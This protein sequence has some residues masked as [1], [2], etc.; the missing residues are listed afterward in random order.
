MRSWMVLLLLC[1]GPLGASAQSDNCATATL[2]TECTLTPSGNAGATTGSDD[3]F[4]P[5]QICAT[6]ADQTVW[7]SFTASQT[8]PYTLTVSNVACSGITQI[9]TGIFSGTCGAL[10]ALN[11]GQGSSGLVTSF[12]AV[13]GQTYFLVFDGAAASDCGFD[14]LVCAG[15]DISA[16]FVPDVITGA[17]PLA[18]NFTNTSVG[19]DVYT[20]DFGAGGATFDG[21]HASFTYD[22]P[23]TYLVTLSAFNGVC[24]TSF[25]DTISVTGS[26]SLQIPNIFTPNE[27]NYNDLFKITCTGIES[28]E[29]MVFNRWGELVGAWNGVK[30][31]W[32]GY[33]VIEGLPV[34]EGTYFYRVLA[35]GYDGVTYDEKGFLQ[36]FR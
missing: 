12:N 3:S 6:S 25:T 10:T 31:S 9:E 24:S 14:V 11:C 23:G 26:S 8:G 17:Y 18:V 13:A 27:D 7:Y 30:G 5:A 1:C 28:L 29:V 22:E 35:T 16:S 21:T 19:G 34:A 4:L 15:C 33:S 36:L 32:D 2:L 20:W